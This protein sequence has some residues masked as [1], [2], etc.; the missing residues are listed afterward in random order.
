M[1]TY[2]I[3]FFGLL[4]I[5]LSA[6]TSSKVVGDGIVMKRKYNKGFHTSFGKNH[7]KIEKSRQ[8]ET[9]NA[10][11]KLDEDETS[12]SE[13]LA[14][15][16]FQQ[17]NENKVYRN[18][19][20][21]S[22]AKV[23]SLNKWNQFNIKR[24]FAAI[25]PKIITNN[26]ATYDIPGEKMIANDTMAYLALAFGVLSILI[27]WIPFVGLLF[28]LLGIVFGAIGMNSAERGLAIAGIITGVVGLILGIGLILLFV[29]A[30]GL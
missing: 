17:N 16:N 22:K 26:T 30:A 20:L 24:T 25:N 19:N 3:S 23:K 13:S 14:D 6:C 8:L 4:V 28:A 1:K 10:A 21:F 7:K 29:L 2:L 11:L 15:N 9:I 5:L 12:P 27:F 18:G